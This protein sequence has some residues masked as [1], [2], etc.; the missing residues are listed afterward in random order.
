MLLGEL[1]LLHV[2]LELLLGLFV[3][4]PLPLRCAVRPAEPARRMEERSTRRNV[5][6]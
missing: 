2:L 1:S 3:F 6:R 4:V 5:F